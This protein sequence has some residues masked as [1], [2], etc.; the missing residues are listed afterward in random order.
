[1]GQEKAPLL[2]SVERV[3]AFSK[4]EAMRTGSP[5]KEFHWQYVGPTNISGRCTDVEAVQPRGKSYTIWVGSATGGVW[6]SV[7]EG[8]T[9]EPVFD[10]MPTASIGDIAIDPSNP[11]IVWVGTGEANIFRSSNAGSGVYRTTDG[12]KSWKLMGLENTHTIGRVRVNPKN[13]NIVYVAATGHEWTTNEERGVFKTTDGGKTWEKILY[14]N[15]M[16]GAYD[17]VL[18]PK[19]PDVIY[20]TTWERIRKKWNDPRT[21]AETRN[22]G[23]WK[24][25]NGGKEWKKI[26]SGLPAPENLGRIGIDISLSNNKVLYA[27]VDNYEIAY[28]ANPGD[29]DSYGRQKAD[30]IKVQQFTVLITGAT[31]GGRL[32]V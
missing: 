21:T 9:F 23:I 6:K 17:L 7:N 29:L 20:C 15:D 16:T 2:N 14:I 13:G 12:G 32:A 27:Y 4:Q 22:C 25:T 28:K 11:D 31:R 1:N 30:V 26:I 24:S 5:Y 3:K 8:T 18:D 19:N 10:D